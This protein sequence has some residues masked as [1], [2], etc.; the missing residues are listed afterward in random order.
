MPDEFDLI[1][2][3]FAPLSGEAGL[4]L[5]D[6]AACYEAKQGYDLIISKDVLV[7]GTHFFEDADPVELATKAVA[8]NVSDLAS[9]GAKPH[10]YFL[11]L[12]LT[13]DIDD[14]WLQS[15]AYGLKLAQK[16][17]DI[18]LAGGDTTSTNHGLFISV[19]ALGH[20]P[21]GTMITRSG[22]KVGD[23]IYVTGTLGDAAFG[24]K[25]LQGEVPHSS[26]QLARYNRPQARCEIGKRLRGIASAAADVSD[27]LIADLGHICRA[28]GVGASVKQD[29]LPLS[30]STEVLL[31]ENSQFADLI[32]SGGDDYELVFTAAQDDRHSLELL[33]SELAIP[34]TRIGIVQ[35][36]EGVRLV[37]KAGKLVQVEKS[38]YQHFRRE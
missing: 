9:K 30:P 29:K 23:D 21:K 11:G 20:T 4:G 7:S 31:K 33:S 25:A 15:F 17:Y 6:D 37:D 2:K 34:I 8:V 36:E 32:W 18:Y 26:Y 1:A 38:G 14:S 27:G 3:Y 16:H 24:L 35:Q 22:A 13:K 10:S 28:S 19:T 12:S 5:L